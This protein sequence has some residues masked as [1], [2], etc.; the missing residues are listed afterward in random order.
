M[1]QQ[2]CLLCNADA[3]VIGEGP[4]N[5]R[6]RIECRTCG[7]Y[8]CSSRVYQ[9]ADFKPPEKSKL[10]AV[11]RERKT[12]SLPQVF[13]VMDKT[14]LPN[15]ITIESLL[16]EYPR[17]ATEMT[18]RTMLNLGRLAR[19]PCDE[20]ELELSDYP[21]L[22]GRGR[23]D[24]I[25]MIR[26]LKSMDYVT[27]ADSTLGMIRLKISAPG[28]RKIEELQHSNLESKQAFVAMWF[29]A[30]MQAVW[31]EGLKRGVEQA[32]S[33]TAIRMDLQEHNEKICDQIIAEIRRSRFVV[34]DF[35]GNRGGVYYE[36][37]FAQGLG[38]PVIWSVRKDWL[39]RVHFDTRQY[40]HIVYENPQELCQALTNRIAATIP[41]AIGKAR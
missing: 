3:T 29:D 5:D 34:A 19:H 11:I 41:D 15:A 36:A 40:N 2:R 4:T 25:Q 33:F 24:M 30:E 22:F 18:D 20:I 7:E 13:L 23:E 6:I 16:G 31:E 8:G 35:T 26:L 38:I 37:G 39:D 1:I 10:Q 17:T 14:V 9:L 21:V 32:G 28:W 12:K 27:D